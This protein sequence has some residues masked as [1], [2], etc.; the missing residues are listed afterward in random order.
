MAFLAA[1]RA[2]HLDFIPLFGERYDLVIPVEQMEGP[3]LQPLL[4]LLREPERTFARSVEA[5][6]GYE[7][8]QMGEVHRVARGLLDDPA[9]AILEIDR[10]VLADLAVSEPA[11]FAA[12]V[13]QVKA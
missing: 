6:G 11:T 13:K 4:A 1:A 5:L 8:T 7:V 3:L 12:I 9:S 2:L 10:K